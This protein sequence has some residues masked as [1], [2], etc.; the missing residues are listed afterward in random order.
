MYVG[1]AAT[2][3]SS[4][5]QTTTPPKPT[6]ISATSNNEVTGISRMDLRHFGTEL[7]TRE[8][9]LAIRADIATRLLRYERIEVNLEGVSD[10]TPSVA[11][12]AFGKLAEALGY[13]VFAE[14]VIF[15]GGTTLI[16]RLIGFVI[17]TR[18]SS[19]H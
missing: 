5:S 19:R 11:D 14:A 6:S 12:E 1:P 18:I 15:I 8:M 9:G 17:K 2:S 7:L 3:S 16:N 13:D 4:A 10:L